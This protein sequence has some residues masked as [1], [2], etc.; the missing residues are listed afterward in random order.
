M[1]A[2]GCRGQRG[3]GRTGRGAKGGQAGEGTQARCGRRRSGWMQ[4]Q[5]GTGWCA[6]ARG[7][8][9]GK[10]RH[11]GGTHFNDVVRGSAHAEILDPHGQ[12]VGTLAGQEV[13]A[14]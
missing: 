6:K 2:E 1:Q 12:L 5:R 13:L 10:G 11:T 7:R 3:G 8:K 9:G 4:R 14:Y